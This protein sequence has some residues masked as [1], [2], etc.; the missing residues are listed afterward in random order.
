MKSLLYIDKDM[1]PDCF[2]D[3]A[4]S[5]S[6]VPTNARMAVTAVPLGDEKVKVAMS[7]Q[8]GQYDI[9]FEYTKNM[10]YYHLD[11]KHF[12]ALNYFLQT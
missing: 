11:T 7:S 5:T 1:N 6:R 4:V 10:M 3:S 12:K 2:R 9:N 8:D